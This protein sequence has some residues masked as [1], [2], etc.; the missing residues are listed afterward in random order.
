MNSYTI[1]H[2]LQDIL[3]EANQDIWMVKYAIRFSTN[4]N[5]NPTRPVNKCPYVLVNPRGFRAS[6]HVLVFSVISLYW[7]IFLYYNY[8][9]FRNLKSFTSFYLMVLGIRSQFK[10]KIIIIMFA[11]R[12]AL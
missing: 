6:K 9:L 7:S 11:G 10:D 2:Y 8:D 3:K 1:G 12:L 4:Y 5:I